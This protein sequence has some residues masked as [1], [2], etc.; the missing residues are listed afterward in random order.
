MNRVMQ[1]A[2]GLSLATSG[3]ARADEAAWLSS[4]DEA[5]QVAKQKNAPMFVV[6]R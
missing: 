5:K 3:F 4:Y 2:I 6:F 1:L